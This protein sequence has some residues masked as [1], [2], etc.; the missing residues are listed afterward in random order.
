MAPEMIR[1]LSHDYS[2]DI[3]SLGILLF[4]LLHGHAPYRG[5]NDHEVCDMILENKPI[6]F[7]QAIS[8]DVK[9]F[10]IQA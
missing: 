5:K 3:W 4:E 6:V 10:V 8:G 7:D 9:N 1:S 2:L